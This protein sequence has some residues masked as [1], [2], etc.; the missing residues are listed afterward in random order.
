MAKSKITEDLKKEEVENIPEDRA[1]KMKTEDGKAIT[2]GQGIL[3][4]NETRS[5]V[6]YLRSM[7]SDK[8]S[9]LPKAILSQH[10]LM[11]GDKQPPTYTTHT[12]EKHFYSSVELSDGIFTNT[13][14]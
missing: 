9:D 10:I 1:K 8:G 14:L 4:P 3:K 5:S 6:I 12:L 7:F 13:F 11:R 2:N